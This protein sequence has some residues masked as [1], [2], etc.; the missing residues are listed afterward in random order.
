MARSRPG[1]RPARPAASGLWPLRRFVETTDD[2]VVNAVYLA[3][4]NQ[5]TPTRDSLRATGISTADLDHALPLLHWRGLVDISVPDVLTVPAPDLA[6]STYAATLERQARNVRSTTA[7]L[8]R[9][10][11]R[12]RVEEG[13]VPPEELIRRLRT[14]DDVT[15]AVMQA[16]PAANESIRAMVTTGPRLERIITGD[17]APLFRRADP[18]DTI[19]R[20]LL[21][22]VDA[23]SNPEVADLLQRADQDGFAIRVG[24][25]VPFHAIVID[26]NLAILEDAVPDTGGRLLRDPLLVRAVEDLIRRTF[27]AGLDV[28]DSPSAPAGSELDRRDRTILT[29]LA[30][31]ATDQTVARRVQVSQR[32]VERRIRALM[33]ELDAK[34]RFQAGVRAAKRALI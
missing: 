20:T 22:D 23:L 15:E 25:S 21:V 8:A 6:L 13:G 32:T 27:T 5:T 19:V 7:E 12:N 9:I 11:R 3:I 28:N 2:P 10:W 4:L 34:T 31:G 18:A 1:A 14:F 30:A 33:D 26:G 16:V 17:L 29:M 24:A